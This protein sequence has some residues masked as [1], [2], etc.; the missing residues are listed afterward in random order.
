MGVISVLFV[1]NVI[2]LH[3][4]IRTQATRR[5]SR[6]LL[7]RLRR[8]RRAEKVSMLSR[9]PTPLVPACCASLFSS[10]PASSNMTGSA[11][12]TTPVSL[13][14]CSCPSQSPNFD[15][16]RRSRTALFTRIIFLVICA[17][18][19]TR[20][21]G[22]PVMCPEIA[23]LLY[24]H[25]FRLRLQL[26]LDRLYTTEKVARPRA[27]TFTVRSTLM[28]SPLSFFRISVMTFVCSTRAD[29][30]WVSTSMAWPHL[31]ALSYEQSK[32]KSVKP[33][34]RVRAAA[35]TLRARFAFCATS[36][37]CWMML[38]HCCRTFSR[39]SWDCEIMRSA[40][41]FSWSTEA[42]PLASSAHD[43][44]IALHCRTRAPSAYLELVKRSFS[45]FFQVLLRFVGI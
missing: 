13:N 14:P 39:P 3:R 23:S 21:S 24:K 27:P 34:T 32:M 25:G 7:T 6:H 30:P 1:R 11:M 41:K 9:L 44:M 42:S 28:R 22:P 10:C 33:T 35:S 17:W 4:D 5:N 18:L 20:F 16:A 43:A 8:W 36:L 2:V 12:L 29:N 26:H 31:P 37:R 15:Q 19:R 38:S 40:L 45:F